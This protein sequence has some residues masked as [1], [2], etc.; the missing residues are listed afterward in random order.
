LEININISELREKKI[1]V[2]TPMYGGMCHG[3]YTKASCDLA[4]TATKYGMDVKFFYLFNESLITR[5]RN[6]LVDEFLRSPYTHLM[7]IDSDINFNPQDVLAVASLCNEDKPIIGAPYPKKCIAWEKVRNAVDAGL[8]DENPNE[9]EKFTGD[10]VFNPVEGTT[11]I[12]IDEPTEVLEVGT[13]FVMIMRE[14]FEKF[15]D[16]YPQFSYKPDHNRSEH[17]D[18]KRY[19]HAF[20]DTVIDNEAYAGKGS[21]G[22]D[23]YLSEDYM[24]CQWARKIGFTTWLCPWMEV[25]H[26]G[27]Y[28]FNGT[29]KDLGRLEF[30]AHGVDDGR[31]LKEERKESRKERRAKERV[32]KK[33][34]KKLTTPEK[35]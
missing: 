33:K 6:Y 31:P 16:E 35:T 29:L 8:G 9:L 26:V 1:F 7:F 3:M 30:A 15:R 20:F 2:G 22:S 13:G 19:I 12:K 32:E 25:N 10:F 34:Q 28:V 5:A 21:G 18:G 24:F 23:R 14:V 17:F 27:T 11:Q 4:T